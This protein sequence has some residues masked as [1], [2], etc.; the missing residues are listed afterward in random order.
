M[1]RYCVLAAFFFLLMRVAYGDI[2]YVAVDGRTTVDDVAMPGVTIEAIPVEGARLPI[3]WP[4]PNPTTASL[5]SDVITGHNNNFFLVSTSG[6]GNG[7]DPLPGGNFTYGP[8]PY[9]G[10]YYTAVDIMLKFSYPG[11]LPVFVPAEA[12]INAY[13][14][15]LNNTE[16][17]LIGIATIDV[18][19]ISSVVTVATVDGS[20]IENNSTTTG[21]FRI[22][23]TGPTTAAHNVTFSISGT[24]TNGTDYQLVNTNATI[25][26]GASSVDIVIRAIDDN[27]VEG[28]ESIILTLA[29]GAEYLV[30]TAS[31]SKIMIT[32]D[33]KKK[34]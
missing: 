2:L 32:D 18:D 33:D 19:M 25:P 10:A 23:R 34:K 26:I 4:T 6:Y 22:A 20:I 27:L 13:W 30:G 8:N 16:L 14:L 31:S 15:S 1:K 12:V 11:C 9:N 5:A 3:D 17:N 29:P 7:Y 28:P 21:R 24:A